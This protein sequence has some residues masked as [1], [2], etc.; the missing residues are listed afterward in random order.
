MN[1][2]VISLF[3]YITV[4]L[5]LTILMVLCSCGTVVEYD[6]YYT[7]P[8]SV[9]VVRSTPYYYHRV[10]PPPPPRRV[11]ATPPPPPSRPMNSPHRGARRR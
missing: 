7:T 8:S 11:H 10:L 4:L 2:K 3:K 5:A 1:N 9:V 6:G